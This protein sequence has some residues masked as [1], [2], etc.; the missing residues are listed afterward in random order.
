MTLAIVV[1][2]GG[3]IG[4]GLTLYHSFS[5]F[6]L[7]IWNSQHLQ[8]TSNYTQALHTETCF[9][10]HGTLVTGYWTCIFVALTWLALMICTKHQWKTFCLMLLW[11]H[12][13]DKSLFA[14]GHIL[15]RRNHD[16]NF[17]KE[18]AVFLVGY[19]LGTWEPSAF[20]RK[21]PW[22]TNQLQMS[23]S[24]SSE[25]WRNFLA[26]VTSSFFLLVLRWFKDPQPWGYQTSLFTW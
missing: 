22:I 10:V 6:M 16:I 9:E 18:T 3:A 2:L 19:S 12:G 1:V 17:I 7:M 21:P 24:L 8:H 20:S 26:T 25:T 11:R 4:K 15:L 5:W 14:T 13:N 23:N